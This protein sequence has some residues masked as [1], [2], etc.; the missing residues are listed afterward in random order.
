MKAGGS[1]RQVQHVDR[2]TSHQSTLIE[3]TSHQMP[4]LPSGVIATPK[5][6]LPSIGGNVSISVGGLVVRSRILTTAALRSSD[7]GPRI[8]GCD[9]ESNCCL[10]SVPVSGFRLQRRWWHRRQGGCTV[11]FSTVTPVPVVTNALVPSD[12]IA[13]LEGLCIFNVDW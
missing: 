10:L 12:V 7:H 8:I 5:G 9:G 13:A 1:H 2:S 11:I 3:V 4:W 6:K